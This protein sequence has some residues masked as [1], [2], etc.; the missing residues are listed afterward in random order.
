MTKSPAPLSTAEQF[1]SFL[2]TRGLLLTRQRRSIL[3]FIANT[4]N[5]HFNAETLVAGMREHGCTVSRATVYRTIIQ[6]YRGGFLR[7]V[8]LDAG[9]T[10]YEFVANVT[11]HEHCFC[12][13]CNRI[14]EF[15]DPTLESAIEK[16]ARRKGFDMTR[17][18]VQIFGIC[19]DCR[20]QADTA[21]DINATT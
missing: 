2:K 19:G 3:D 21:G 9:Q 8:A 18:S 11:H 6:L 13:V 17:H 12:E 16:I 10:Y 7:E 20:N 1:T 14:I 4:G 15:T 5:Q